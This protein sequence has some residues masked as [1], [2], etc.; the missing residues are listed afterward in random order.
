MEYIVQGYEPKKLFE[1]FEEICAIPHG[2]GNEAAIA[3]YLVDFAKARG[4]ECHRDAVNNVFI[5]APAT[6]GL[7]DRPAILLQGHTD[8][9]CEKNNDTEHDFTKD[10][11]KLFVEDGWLGAKGTTL[12]GDD[13]IAV[14]MMMAILDGQIPHPAV[15]CLFTVEEEVGLLGAESFDYSLVSAQRM[16]NM[17]SE[18]EA[19][20]TAGCAGGLRTD[21]AIPVGYTEAK[22]TALKISIGG[23]AGGHS[24]ADVHRGR[25]NANK[26]MGR[27]LLALSKEFD[28]ALCSIEGGSKDNAIPREC[29]AVICGEGLEALAERTEQLAGKLF[30]E[31]C[32]EDAGFVTTVKPVTMP[33]ACLDQDS[34]T[35]IICTIATV[36]SGVLAMS[37]N[38]EGLVEYSRNLGIIRTEQGSVHLTLSSRS[39][40]ESQLDA[41]INE[42][43]ALAAL[44]AGSARHHSRYPGWSYAKE[45][46]I[47]DEYL[48]AYAALF[49]K[50]PEVSVIHAG[51]EC[52]IIRSRL[53]EMDMI[54]V[55][56]NMRNIH[57]PDERL[58]LASCARFWQ[59]IAY[60]MSK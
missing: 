22:G 51:L 49:G 45:S 23:L 5:K 36:A 60:I 54:S 12:G 58:D 4:L 21:L 27:M 52:G 28:F 8:M 18:D 55:G 13:G 41:S 43:D 9:V 53:P 32:A 26:L 30:A 15:E 7:E 25:A 46:P 56:P 34:T 2:S 6:Q 1:Y 57:S 59:V 33:E 39:A 40:I 48:A 35:R 42:L 38:I 29:V 16:I 17:D 14:A 20:V 24:G 31:M 11:L 10:G 47:R 44:C 37:N 3:Q 50:T 19:C